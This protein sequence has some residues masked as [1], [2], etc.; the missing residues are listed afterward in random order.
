MPNLLC[1]K[2][3]RL[4]NIRHLWVLVRHTFWGLMSRRKKYI[5]SCVTA[6]E[7]V[8][9][10][11]PSLGNSLMDLLAS[12]YWDSQIYTSCSGISVGRPGPTFTVRIQQSSM[13]LLASLYWDLYRTYIRNSNSLSDGY[14]QCQLLTYQDPNQ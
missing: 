13:D 10:F 7:C 4:L 11:S 14:R 5:S 2:N 9:F 1:T 6:A 3:T 12:S 8:Y